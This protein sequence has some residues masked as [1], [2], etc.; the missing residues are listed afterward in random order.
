MVED[1]NV[2]GLVTEA[3]GCLSVAGDDKKAASLLTD[4][5]YGTHDPEIEQQVRDLAAQGLERAGRF[6][7]VR[8]KESIHPHSPPSRPT[9]VDAVDGPGR[10]DV[11]L[12]ESPA[13][14]G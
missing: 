14:G 7:K 11:G 8:W 5:A 12:D 3:R 4:A 10:R 9:R 13:R 2:A 1:P 6:G